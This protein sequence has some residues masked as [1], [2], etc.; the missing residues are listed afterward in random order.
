MVVLD[1]DILVGVLRN[2][3]D[4]VNFMNILEDRGEKLNTTAINAFE[5]FQG[6]LLLSDKEKDRDVENLLKSLDSANYN[7][8]GS[9]SWK[10]AQISASLK[11]KGETLD[12][13]DIAIAAIAML[14]DE[15]IVTRNI[16]HFK[17]IKGLK[18]EK[19]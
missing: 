16:K 14:R 9:T 18:I 19:W 1:T 13:Q 2:N 15:A 10:A 17:R 7:F 12:F 3:K 8:D 6:A 11:K 4:A 5:L